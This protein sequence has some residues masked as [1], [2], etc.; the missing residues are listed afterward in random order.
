[1]WL[2]G[3]LPTL[4]SGQWRECESL[5]YAISTSSSTW[6]RAQ[7]PLAGECV[8]RGGLGSR[9]GFW[10]SKVDGKPWARPG[11]AAEGEG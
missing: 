7:A 9:L 11:S 2:H 8:V 10:A 5:Q 1:M 4:S 3:G 6:Q